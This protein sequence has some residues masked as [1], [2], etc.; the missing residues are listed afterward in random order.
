M[1]CL[2]AVALAFVA[3]TAQADQPGA[4]RRPNVLVIIT[5]DQGYGDLSRH[6]N[7][8]LK[9]PHLD[10]LASGGVELTQFYVS[11][12]CAPTRASLMT[13]R[14]NYRTRVVDTYLGRA[15][16]DPAEVTLAE[17]LGGAGYR[18]GL[19]GKWHLGDNFPM[20]PQDQGFQEVLMH[21]GGGIGQPSDPPG[22]ESY[23]DPLLLH[24]GQLV[25][26]KGYCSDVF[27]DAALR[28]IER[29]R[30]KPFFCYLA[31]NAPHAP[32]QVP[33]Q[34]A[35]TYRRLIPEPKDDTRGQS[36][37]LLHRDTCASYG[38]IANIDD[39]VGR[40]LARLDALKLA[41]DTLVIFLT[42]NGPPMNRYNANLRGRK[43][44]VYDGG[45][46][47]PCFVRL[48]G[49]PTG[50][51]KVDR[52][53]AHIDL[54]PTV[55]DV[56]GVKPPA[57]VKFDGRSLVKLL[58]GQTA[59]WPDRT[60]FFQW[61]RGDVP[62]MGRAFAARSQRW[63]LVQPIA[64]ADAEPRYQLFDMTADPTEK[65][66]LAAANSEVVRR[67]RAS[68]E[69][70]F[71]DVASTR[72]FDPPPIHLGTPHENPAV[73]T[74]QDW[75]GAKAGWQPENRGHWEVQVARGGVY[76]VTVRLNRG[77]E[78]TVHLAAGDVRHERPL[79]RDAKVCVFDAVHL[80]EG[81][82]RVEAW[83][84]VGKE[85]A[86]AWSAEVKRLDTPPDSAKPA[87]DPSPLP[88]TQP[89]TVQGDIARQ[90][91]SGVREFL[92]AETERA[93]ADRG[94]HWKRDFSSAE[95]YNRSVE[96]NRKRLAHILGVRDPRVPFDSPEL[97]GTLDRPALVGRGAGYEIHAIRWP[98]FGDVHGEGLLLVPA[99]RKT[100]A[101][102]VAIPDADQTPEQLCGLVEG[103]PPGSQFARLLA[104]R[105]CRVAV[106]ALIDRRLEKRNGRA[107]LTTREFLYR[108]AFELGRHLI[109]YEVQK[110]LA[111]VDWFSREAGG[112]A[113]VGVMGW[114]E[115]G[116][117]ALYAAAVDTRI[118]AAC[119]SGYFDDRRGL[120]QGP[121]DRNVFGLLDQFGDAELATL[122]APRALI[123]EA[124]RGPELV[125][126]SQGGAPAT[127]K[128][129]SAESAHREFKRVGELLSGLDPGPKVAFLHVAGGGY[130]S[131]AS[132]GKLVE[133]VS[134]GATRLPAVADST[135]KPHQT[136]SDPGPRQA[137]Q[138]HEI[139]RHT[140]AL[141]AES[142]Y[143]R[144]EFMK[145]LDTTSLPAY[146]KSAEPYRRAFADEVIGRFDR[147]RLP[148]NPRS[149]KAYDNPTWTGHEVVL[150]V[151]PNVIA[152]G[153]LL[154]PK[155]LKPGE[156]R[157]VVVCQHGLEGRPQDV[158][159]GDHPAYHDF[160]AKL[161][162]RGFITFAPQ[163]LYI[164]RDDFR[165]LQRIANPLGKTLFSVVVPQHQQIVDW[166]K[167]LPNVDPARIAFYGLSYGGKT[168][169]RVPALVTDYCLSICSADFNEWVWKNASTRSPYSYVWTGEYEIFEFDL[170]GTFNYAEMA[171]L[172]APRPF[173][174]ER[175]H[176][177]GVAPDEAVAYEF[178]KVRHLYQ[179]R[180][181]L[182]AGHCE[183]EWFVGPHTI[184]G[185]G[186]FD[187][188]HRHLSWPKR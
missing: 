54:A 47:V 155:D 188:L 172:I 95:A 78:G 4:G 153:I 149:R 97:V 17:V 131:D 10:R 150:D 15:M 113:K 38:M 53:A 102:V 21:R 85:T 94:R 180:L 59:T 175:G 182:P 141:L 51:A 166:L 35:E 52:I 147:P 1:R 48:P 8:V 63:K 163:N 111:L 12:V 162:E 136:R 130:G 178:A 40:L 142:P 75:R 65:N 137:R 118:D 92:L 176:F 144:A 99:G 104:E 114:G 64:P 68:Y 41:K 5:D 18:T 179:A 107:L 3:A 88:G 146:L 62:Q 27:T 76:E 121:I 119:V 115:G 56:C 167:T 96:P 6:G 14:W 71:K 174:V 82:A 135:P 36:A 86:G 143:V 106:P 60:L 123:I 9:T 187:F 74:R 103:T 177:D 124:V 19:F 159:A 139:D 22:G 129:P 55:L 116:L 73:L 154:L 20:R 98:A 90:L 77:G 140:Q 127:L 66:D 152:Y 160:A 138:K 39:N 157:P 148:L 30:D 28:F 79:K 32:Y 84:A 133:A 44:T 57:D 110:V 50:G 108:S 164:F 16:M 31:F 2:I 100:I 72:G 173:M 34:Y 151:F 171:A 126:P 33:P 120:W 67:L 70:W 168:A 80:K 165:V 69:S 43:G 13:G 61:H 26:T 117:L 183:I 169:M 128:S 89:L 170:G 158:I 109:G 29:E 45:I 185:K 81:P 181:K 91:V 184:N 58:E 125:L 49:R 93:A 23:F 112:D 37:K 87:A 25:K 7:P 145:R 186:T 11:P 83:T 101:D 105:G 156:R 42:D 122:V 46:R 24:N 134:P 132:M 161:A